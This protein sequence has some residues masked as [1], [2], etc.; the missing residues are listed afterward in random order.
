MKNEWFSVLEDDTPQYRIDNM[1]VRS[2][3]NSEL[4]ALMFSGNGSSLEKAKKILVAAGNN[5]ADLSKMDAGTLRNMGLTKHE[6][7]RLE[8]VWEIARRKE[9]TDACKKKQLTGSND[10]YELMAS[11]FDGLNHEEFWVIL[12]NR[13]NRVVDKVRV[14]K[15]GIS[16]IV[17]DV[18]IILRN[19]LLNFASSMILCH[20]HPSGNLKPSDADC[21]I[22]KKIQEAAKSMDITVLDHVIIADDSYYSFSDERMI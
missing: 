18:R 7:D 22:T 4:I 17:I 19:C 5:L 14:S 15:G 6:T 2:L 9:F 21:Q 3:S 11:I 10:V 1:G 13:A 16:G 12:L 8:V 20:N